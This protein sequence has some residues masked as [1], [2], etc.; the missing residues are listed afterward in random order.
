MKK[1]SIHLLVDGLILADSYLFLFNKLFS[2]I[3]RIS[4][5]TN[6]FFL[7][8]ENIDENILAVKTNLY[9]VFLF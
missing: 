3:E 7:I 1:E 8:K 5:K 9:Q 6:M 2:I 4:R